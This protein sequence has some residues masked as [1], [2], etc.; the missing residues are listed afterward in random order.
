MSSMA[1]NIKKL[2]AP[3]P[4]YE[5][6]DTSEANKVVNETLPSQAPDLNM[7]QERNESTEKRAAKLLEQKQKQIWFQKLWMIS[8]V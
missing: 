8:R 7:A 6:E 3:N 1:L 5:V 2:E 4:A